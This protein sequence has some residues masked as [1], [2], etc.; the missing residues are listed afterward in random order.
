MKRALF[1]VCI[2]FL[3]FSKAHA[4]EVK[5]IGVNGKDF[6]IKS[7]LHALY[8]EGALKPLGVPPGYYLPQP[9]LGIV[10]K[11]LKPTGDKPHAYHFEFVYKKMGNRNIVIDLLK[12]D[13]RDCE[14]GKTIIL[15]QKPPTDPIDR[16]LAL[17]KEKQIELIKKLEQAK[18]VENTEKLVKLL[19]CVNTVTVLPTARTALAKRLTRMTNKTLEGY[20][21]DPDA[22]LREAA[23][24]A[25]CLKAL[26]SRGESR[27]LTT[28]EVIQKK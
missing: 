3:L 11:H 14:S 24:V 10:K 16:F 25:R 22:H 2:L 6:C 18:G 20:L 26:A 12:I 7:T 1:S 9:F 28:E 13:K 23:G 8:T 19:P 15:W 27:E 17:P 4:Q 21:A 5:S